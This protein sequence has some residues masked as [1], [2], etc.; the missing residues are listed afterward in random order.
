MK[1]AAHIITADFITEKVRC[2]GGA[3]IFKPTFEIEEIHELNNNTVFTLSKSNYEYFKGFNISEDN[4]IIGLSNGDGN[5][6]KKKI[7]SKNDLNYTI[8]IEGIL[9]EDFKP[10]IIILYGKAGADVI[11]GINSDSN[12]AGGLLKSQSLV[13]EGFGFNNGNLN[14]TVKLL[15]GDLTGAPVKDIE[16]YGLYADN[17]YLHGG[18]VTEI[19]AEGA[20]LTYAGVNTIPTTVDTERFNERIVFWAGASDYANA[21]AS[22]FYVTE[23]GSI[24]AKQG[25]FEGSVISESF[26]AKSTIQAATIEGTG[27]S[28]SLKIYDTGNGGIS[29]YKKVENIDNNTNNE[30]SNIETRDIETLRISNDGIYCYSYQG[31]SNPI[32]GFS[33]NNNNVIFRPTLININTTE[34]S[35]GSFKDNNKISIISTQGEIENNASTNITNIAAII[36][37]QGQIEGSNSKNISYQ[38]KDNYYCLFVE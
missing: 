22:P 31:I 24:Y 9:E 18:L 17:V 7:I 15:L 11:I 29:F 25:I 4:V 12:D 38:Q 19:P 10:N 1:E 26:I 14:P 35:Q 30:S 23:Q 21:A 5:P 28:P 16:G 37:M 33:E 27:S 13:I 20:D 34:I 6:L 3:F 2:M 36:K 32:I 8:S